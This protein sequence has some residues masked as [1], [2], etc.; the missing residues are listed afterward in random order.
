MKAASTEA[1]LVAMPRSS[2]NPNKA[3]MELRPRLGPG[4]G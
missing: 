1:D 2:G 3:P 4:S